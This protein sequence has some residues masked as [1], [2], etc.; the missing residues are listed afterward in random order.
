MKRNLLKQHFFGTVPALLALTLSL[1]VVAFAG[2]LEDAQTS[3]RRGDYSSAKRYAE[4]AISANERDPR[5]YVALGTILRKQGDDAGAKSAWDNVIRLDPGLRS[6]KDDRGF[7]RSYRAVGGNPAAASSGGGANSGGGAV[8]G[9]SEANAIINALS[10]GSVYVHPDLAGEVDTARI[11]QATR[12]TAPTIVKVVVVPKLGPYPSRAAFAEDLRKQLNLGENGAVVVA[13]PKGVSGVSERLSSS[14]V[15]KSFDEAGIGP[16]F[17]RGGLNEAV[18]L[19]V[20]TFG[21]TVTDD[22]RGDAN[23][24]GLIGL[25]LLGLVG[26]GVGFYGLKKKREMDDAKEPVERIRQEVLKNLSYVDGYLDLLPAGT[27]SDRAKQFRAQAYEKYATASATLQ[28]AKKP[29]EVRAVYPM[30]ERALAELNECRADIDRATGGTGVAMAIPEI[31]D[32]STDATRA[33]RYRRVEDLRNQSEADR[34]QREVESIPQNER[35]VSFFSGQPMP[36]S[37]LVPVTMVIDGQKRTVMATREEAEQIKRG[38]TPA[39]RAF[40]DGRGNYVPWYEHRGYDPYQ[41]YYGGWGMGGGG[42]GTFVNLML[43]SHMF[44]GGGIFGGYGGWGGWG[45]GMG[46]GGW[47]GGYGG[48]TIVNN[49]YGDGYGG[50]GG[51]FGGSDGSQYDATPDNS[52]G[53]DFFGQGGY[54]EQS[55]DG[56]FGFGD[57]G[58]DGGFGDFGGDSGGDFGGGDFGGGGDW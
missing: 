7:L 25:G 44:S 18:P 35:G 11:E 37:A 46:Y 43:L 27:E 55:S 40:D 24:S 48:P 22:R 31:P 23:R 21:G 41:S 2:P 51:F 6:V 14:Q 47:G 39:V 8:R 29:D 34:L 4:Q 1:S 20:K 58:G 50:N 57:S 16:A 5:A 26:G 38:E 10:S 49:N 54:S 28:S 52:G 30:L 53:T 17:A 33:D 3:Y 15:E 12:A 32:L 42:L 36:K 45:Y 56:G 13:T 19:A 9:N